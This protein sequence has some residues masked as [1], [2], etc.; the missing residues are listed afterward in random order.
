MKDGR[1]LSDLQARRNN[2]QTP[3]SKA[4]ENAEKKMPGIFS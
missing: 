3:F 1:H 4:N 2:I